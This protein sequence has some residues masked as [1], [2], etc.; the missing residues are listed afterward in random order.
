LIDTGRANSIRWAAADPNQFLV[1]V[2]IGPD[3]I[4]TDDDHVD[5]CQSD[6]AAWDR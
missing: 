5:G 3:A 4:A 2:A 1:D 6:R